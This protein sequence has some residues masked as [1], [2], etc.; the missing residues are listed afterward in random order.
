MLLIALAQIIILVYIRY[1]SKITRLF[2]TVAC[3]LLKLEPQM[4]NKL[5]LIAVMF[6]VVIGGCG[7]G[8]S[9]LIPEKLSDQN[10]KNGVWIQKDGKHGFFFSG[11]ASKVKVKTGANLV[12]AKSGERSV[13]EVTVSGPYVNVFVNKPLDP[14]GDGWPNKVTITSN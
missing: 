3:F 11:D 6:S 7:L 4:K 14:E 8:D 9:H 5:S 1:W 10:W 12:F 13:T 2:I